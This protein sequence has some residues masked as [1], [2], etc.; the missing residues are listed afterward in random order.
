[1]IKVGIVGISGY[2]GCAALEILLKHPK[3]RLTYLSANNTEGKVEEI[4]PHLNGLTDLMCTKFD[5]HQAI[6]SADLFFLG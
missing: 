2:S 3:V 5:I 1:M 4:W 6:K